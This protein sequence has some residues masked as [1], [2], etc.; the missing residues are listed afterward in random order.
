MQARLLANLGG[1]TKAA[2]SLVMVLLVWAG[3]SALQIFPEA[4]FP[5]PLSVWHSAVDLYREGF[6]WFPI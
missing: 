5:S 1:W 6:C 3:V 2:S 4:I